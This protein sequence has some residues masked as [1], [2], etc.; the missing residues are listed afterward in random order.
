M[1]GVTK[2]RAGN[3]ARLRRYWTKGEGL[4][5]WA[6]SPHPWSTLHGHLVKHIPN[7]DL[8]AR[9]TETYYRAV[10]HKPSGWRK[11]KN[12]LGPG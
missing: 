1:A 5:K 2:S 4:A 6:A 9:L 10:F 8:A 12:P 7:P 3:G 11:G